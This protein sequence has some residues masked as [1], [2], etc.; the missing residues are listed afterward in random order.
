[1]ANPDNKKRS[2]GKLFG[3]KKVQPLAKAYKATGRLG[4]RNMEV[5]NGSKKLR[6]RRLWGMLGGGE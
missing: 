5:G 4:T 1:M 6:L 2:D 3:G